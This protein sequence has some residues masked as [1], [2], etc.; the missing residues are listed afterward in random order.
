[1]RAACLA[2][3]DDDRVRVLVLGGWSPG[4]LAFLRTRFAT[5]CIFV[6]PELHMPPHGFNWCCTWQALALVSAPC[7]AWYF[8]S[9]AAVFF[10]L[11]A[12]PLL[13]LLLVRGSVR[14]SIAAAEAAIALHS[15]EIVVGFSW[16][17]GVGCW[18]LR[19]PYVNPQSLRPRLSGWAGPTLL[20]APTLH[21]MEKA[22]FLP[23][24]EPFF[25]AGRSD[26]AL[27][28]DL[29]QLGKQS[30][31]V[32]E[33]AATSTELSNGEHQH[34][35][36][37]C[38]VAATR[39]VHIFHATHDGFCPESQR[40]AL[41]RTGASVHICRDGHTLERPETLAKIES[42]FGELLELASA[43]ENTRRG[44]GGSSRPPLLP[45]CLSSY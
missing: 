32:G 16:G 39:A 2:D 30:A 19:E 18:L 24:R 38:R 37:H 12:W 15:I 29:D 11:A 23:A 1:M 20:L 28:P 9:V 21:A 40:R 8:A 14:R 7:G 31:K 22:A 34:Q 41:Q 44:L 43:C 45:T 17:G 3:D 5:S 4:P 33:E 35:Q 13:V 6:E 10:L 42:V 27:K 26:R 25:D 36:P